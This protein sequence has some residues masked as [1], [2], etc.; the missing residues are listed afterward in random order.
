MATKKQNHTLPLFDQTEMQRQTFYNPDVSML[1]RIDWKMPAVNDMPDWTDAKRVCVDVECKDPDLKRLGPGVRRPGNKIVGIGFSI[2]DGPGYYL[3]IAHEGGDNCDWNVRA[4]VRDQ[5]RKFRGV[6]TGCGLQYDLDWISSFC[7]EI[8]D[9]EVEDVQILD[10]LIDELQDEY[11][12]DTLCHRY[13]LPGKDETLLREVA[14]IY[15]VH[16]KTGLYRLPGRY[17]DA[18]GRADATRP[19]VIY[20]RQMEQV[21]KLGLSRIWNLERQCTVPLVEMRQRGVRVDVDKLDVIEK[22]TIEKE[23]EELAK[24]RH[25][26]GVRIAVGDVWKAELYQRALRSQGYECEDGLDKDELKKCGELGKRLI[27]AREWNRLRTTNVKQVRESMVEHGPN[28][29]RVHCTFNQLKGTD[30]DEEHGKKK[31]RGVRYGRTSSTS[32]NMQGQPTRHPLFGKL[33]RS[34]YVKDLGSEGWDCSDWSQQE[35]RIGVHYAEELGLP[36]AKEFADEYRR[37]PKLDVHQKLTDLAN[38]PVN[39]P[40]VKVKNFVNGR[41]YGMGDPKLCRSLE[42]PLVYEMRRD[43][44]TR[45]MVRKLV[46]GPEGQWVID[47][48]NKFAPWI[49]LLVRE[50]SSVAAKYGYV[51]DYLDRRCNFKKGPDGKY[52]DT[53]KA[54]NRIGQGSAAGQMKATLIECRKAGIPIQTIIHDEFNFS[55]HDLAQVRKLK[56]LQENTVRFNVP[57]NVDT[58]VGENWGE[59]EKIAA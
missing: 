15:R 2:E 38:D 12:L 28:N 32:Y 31:G 27:L 7:P 56:E 51:W 17:V 35:P 58:E 55:Y 21:K 29:W 40:R 30:E 6:I 46:P 54:F 48:F 23:G 53:H 3:P 34:V 13:E 20:R 8:M 26:T 41:L 18:Y 25:M 47:Q 59:V 14:G 45:E 33:W 24:V 39:M 10:V 9:R 22:L 50:A 19:H 43:W 1:P 44:K 37:N 5:I 52:W 49:T 4:Y 11:D 16:P 57:M 42:L 36:G